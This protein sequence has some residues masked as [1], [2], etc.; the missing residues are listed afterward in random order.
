MALKLNKAEKLNFQSGLDEIPFSNRN[1]LIIELNNLHDE[2]I[3][4]RAKQTT[5]DV[6]QDE[7]FFH[8]I[9]SNDI[10]YFF[11]KEAMAT[12]EPRKLLDAF[13]TSNHINSTYEW[14]S[15]YDHCI[16][17]KPVL[18]CYAGNNYNLV[19]QYLKEDIGKS[20]NGHRFLVAAINIILAIRG[21][22]DKNEIR[23]DSIKF[24][25]KKNTQFETSIV[26]ALLGILNEN[27]LE[28]SVH[29]NEVTKYHKG[30]KWLHE[31]GNPIGKYLPFFSYGLYSVAY[32]HNG[33]DFLKEIKT[34][35]SNIWW[36][37]FVDFN[38]NNSF[39]EGQH[40]ATFEGNL[41]CINDIGLQ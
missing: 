41:K 18:Y 10:L 17:L 3:L 32:K 5:I 28:V 37:K 38:I 16:R 40:V 23:E 8:L 14:D 39:Q 2:T 27:P 36:Q 26:N 34:P 6:S 9:K 12:D 19:T 21:Q 20:K 24:L 7:M 30:S 4:R 22:L 25:N 1:E 11:Y 29:L 33:I 15:G 35:E 31:F 13:F